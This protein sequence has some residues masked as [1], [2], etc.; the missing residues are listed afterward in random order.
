MKKMPLGLQRRQS[1]TFLRG[2]QQHDEHQ[3]L[4]VEA[5]EIL[6]VYKRKKITTKEGN[7][8]GTGC[9]ERHWGLC[10]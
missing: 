9:T 5:R 6:I 4:Q 1:Q 3:R 8:A 2:T 7:Q 10:P